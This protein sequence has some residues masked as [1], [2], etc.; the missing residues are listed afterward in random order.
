MTAPALTAA[1]V[2]TAD[3]EH[4]CAGLADE[5]ASMSG[6]RLLIIGGAGFLGTRLARALLE[7]GSLAGRTI[8]RLV[9][10]DLV[11]P[12]DA[13]LRDD[14]R[15]QAHAG[16]LLAQLPGLMRTSFDAVFHLA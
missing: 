11:A 12:A 1:D 4:I 7:R 13:G 3:L 15:V 10:A 6:K 8:R 5:F 14:P 9:L 16:D 2:V